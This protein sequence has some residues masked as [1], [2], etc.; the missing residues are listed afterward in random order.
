MGC[1]DRWQVISLICCYVKFVIP[2]VVYHTVWIN[3]TA[4]IFVKLMLNFNDTHRTVG[5]I[6]Y[7]N[8]GFMCSVLL[9]VM[10]YYIVSFV[11]TW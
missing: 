1:V 6:C 8:A 10:L 5:K 11:C 9:T 2:W 3:N 7:I 4:K